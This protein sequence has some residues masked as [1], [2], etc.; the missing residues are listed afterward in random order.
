MLNTEEKALTSIR[1]SQSKLV[2]ELKLIRRDLAI[3][4]YTFKRIADL[5]SAMPSTAPLRS[6]RSAEDSCCRSAIWPTPK[7]IGAR[8]HGFMMT[9]QEI[10]RRAITAV[11]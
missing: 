11:S 5:S 3:I 8:R 6:A 4:N 1:E 7:V 10:L 9:F 2:G